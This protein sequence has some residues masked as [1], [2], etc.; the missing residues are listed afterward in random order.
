[1]ANISKKDSKGRVLKEG[2]DQMKDGRYRFRYVNKEG[3]RIPVYSWKLV[4]SDRVPNGKKDGLSLREKEKEIQ[5]DLLDGINTYDGNQSLN[6]VFEQYIE[7]KPNLAPKTLENYKS[8]WKNHVHDGI[9]RIAISKIKRSDILRLYGNLYSKNKMA[10]GSIQLLQNVLY[11]TFQMAVDDEI[12]RSNPC[13]NCMKNFTGIQSKERKPL[14]KQEQQDLLE[15]LKN[16]SVY[17]Y[18][19][20]TMMFLLLA[21]G[22]RIGECLGLTWDNIDFDNQE[23][24]IDH[25][26]V[27]G[28][29]NG[30][31]KHYIRKPKYNSERT[32][33]LQNHVLEV[34]KEY[35]ADYYFRSRSSGIEVDGYSNFIFLNSKSNLNK[36]A[37]INR[38][39]NGMIKEFNQLYEVQMPHFSAHTLRHTFCTRMAENGV[40]PKVLQRLM[41]HKSITVTMEIYNHVDGDRVRKEMDRVK[42][43]MEIVI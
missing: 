19:Y 24:K 32:I 7:T 25:Q 13:K 5:K 15:F 27:Y 10:V 20:Y 30:K 17:Y 36:P 3:K 31:T 23:L 29:V 6:K 28:K 14:T 18:H 39:I 9:G 12:L 34:M 22:M 8:Y 26:L 35:K 33:P 43:I 42:D 11:P 16:D 37:T 38:A 2:E 4:P 1:M 40:D 41:G 21:T